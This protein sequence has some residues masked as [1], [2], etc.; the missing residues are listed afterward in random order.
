ME[1][2]AHPKRGKHSSQNIVAPH[3]I[4][5]S[6]K[7]GT[8]PVKR[9]TFY[10]LSCGRKLRTTR[11]FFTDIHGFTYCNH[12]CFATYQAHRNPRNSE[13]QTEY[14]RHAPRKQ[15]GPH[16]IYSLWG[17]YAHL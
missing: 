11:Q 2:K 3:N 4:F 12:Q 5:Q 15:P 6:A 10:C 8:A 14:A 17:K 7:R 9:A 16:K 13:L 1:A